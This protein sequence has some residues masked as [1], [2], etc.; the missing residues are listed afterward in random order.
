[1]NRRTQVLIG[2]SLVALGA[3]AWALGLAE[4]EAGVRRVED[5]VAAPAAFAAREHVLLGVPQPARV[6][7]SAAQGT[8]LQDN[9]GWSNATSSTVRWTDAAGGAWYSTRTV[10]VR[11]DADGAH[12]TYRNETRRLPADPAPDPAFPPVTVEWTTPGPVRAFAIEAFHDSTA[13]TPRIWGLYDGPLKDPMQP[14]PS[15]FTGRLLSTLPDG[16]PVPDGAYLYDVE[17]F[18][19]GCSSKFLP[20]EEKERLRQSGDL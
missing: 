1:V 13:D 20:P 4:G 12:W 7:V 5:V 8:V 14:K 6:P 10:S 16:R 18:K 11:L 15:Q 9:P 19:A 3:G 2:L 17:E